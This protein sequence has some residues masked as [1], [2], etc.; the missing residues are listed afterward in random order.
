MADRAKA[1]RGRLLG[2]I[3]AGLLVS[4]GAGPS[5]A[6]GEAPAAVTHKL[7]KHEALWAKLAANPEARLPVIVRFDMPALPDAASFASPAAVDEAHTKAIRAAQDRILAATFPQGALSS[8][9]AAEKNLKRMDFSPMFG[10]VASADEIARLATDPSVT[11]IQEDRLSKPSLN[12]SLPLIQMPAM[13]AAG[14]TGNGHHVAVL[15]TGGRRSHQFLSSRINSEACYNTTGIQGSVSQ[16]PG[17]ASSST[18]TGSG[19]DCTA[20]NIYGCGHGTHVAGTVAGYNTSPASGQ[21]TSGVARD[22]RLISINVF[23]RFPAN[24]SSPCGA[25]PG[26]THCVLTFDTD[27]IRGLERVYALRNTYKIAAVNMSLGGGEVSA[28]CD[29]D[30]RKPIIDQ[31]KAARIATVIAAGNDGYDSAVGAPG[32]ISSAVTVGSSTKWDFRSDFSNWGNLIDVV[33]PGS[34]IYSSYIN[35]SANNYFS[36]SSGTSMASPHVAGAFAA[37]RNAFPNATVDQ[38]ENALKSTGEGISSAGVVKPR[39]NVNDA[40]IVL[41][42]G[43]PPPPPT[44][45]ANNHFV[46]R[47][48][49]PL[50]AV[51]GT[52]TV[53]GSNVGGTAEGG[54]PIHAGKHSALNSVWWRYTPTASGAITIDTLGSNF[55]TVLAVYRGSSVGSLA[56]V[57]SNDDAD[58]Y[59]IQSQVRFN[60]TAGVEYQIAVA[61]YM[62]EAGNIRLSVHGGV[63]APVPPANDNFANRIVIPPHGAINGPRSVTGNNTHATAQAGEPRHANRSVAT[64]SVWWRYTPATSGRITIDTNGSSFNTVLA[65]YTGTS[66]GGLRVVAEND[67]DPAL[68][69]RSKVVF[70]G[71]AGT[72]YQIAV[73]GGFGNNSGH[74]RMTV[75]GGGRYDTTPRPENDNFANR[76]MIPPHGAIFGP[77]SVTA[78]NTY[79]TA[80]SGEP[81]HANRPVATNSL[82]WRYTPATSGLITIDTRGSSFNTVLAVYTGNS[83]RGLRVVV[84]NDDDPDLGRRSKV[85]FNGVAGTQYQIAVAGGFGNNSGHIRMTVR[86]GGRHVVSS[87][88]DQ[89]ASLSSSGPTTPWPEGTASPAPITVST[90]PLHWPARVTVAPL[91]LQHDDTARPAGKAREVAND[92]KRPSRPAPTSSVDG[93]KLL[94]TVVASGADG[95]LP[96]GGDESVA[97]LAVTNAGSRAARVMAELSFVSAD[98]VSIPVPAGL[99][100]CRTDTSSGTCVGVKATSV[101]FDAEPDRVITFAAFASS[102]EDVSALQSGHGV[103]QVRFRQGNDTIGTASLEIGGTHVIGSL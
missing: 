49:V 68:G 47:I 18:A 80:E 73:A 82:W 22:A 13:Y 81:L 94:S 66:V 17:G 77:R 42:G 85:V 102:R 33:A 103:L 92:V 95:P 98:G 35:G 56:E 27:Q 5:V 30:A 93:V 75:R 44:G 32:C 9:A 37:L 52:R 63:A 43:T 91:A 6:S 64:N 25:I 45:P 96:D 41:G 48:T 71:V 23:S 51:G 88:G 79:A 34:D 53:T 19:E 90:S 55:D 46:N 89:V 39:I 87:A 26:H 3:A 59:T 67:D 11:L 84:A 29:N 10:I 31:L 58:Y 62:N 69:R 36:F 57:A 24:S 16:C 1:W 86:G 21:P 97:M 20:S 100:I 12:E 14:A 7:E 15:D 65:V 4:T 74:I 72:Q 38:I 50:P 101:V 70:N 60:A 8:A 76:T 28:H 40:R 78:N 83:V 61:G 99:S 54:E 2:A